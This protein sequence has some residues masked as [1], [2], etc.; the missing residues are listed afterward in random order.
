MTE[1]LVREHREGIGIG[2]QFDEVVVCFMNTG[3]EHEATLE[4]VDR[5]DRHF[6]WGV[7]WL[8]AV[9]HHGERKG[10]THRVVTFETASRDGE[11]FEEY[12]RKYGL[13]NPVS[14]GCSNRLKED[15]LKS[16]LREIEWGAFGQYVNAVGIRADEADRMSA[17]HMA[18]NVIYPMI[19]WGMTKRAVGTAMRDWPFDLGIPGDHYGNC[20]WCWKKSL[21]KHLT[22]MK[23]SPEVFDFPA[24]LERL[25]ADKT[26]GLAKA[27]ED[28]ITR[29]FR[30]HRTTED[31]RRLAEETDFEP[32]RDDPFDHGAELP[33]LDWLDVGGGC[34]ESCE[35]FAD[36]SN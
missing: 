31:L 20:T 11:P 2:G 13:P 34:G 29:M 32:Y 10:S 24:K 6:G 21:R 4:F 30:G 15:V 12:V 28:G 33:Q 5:C 16:Y 35:V 1:R 17:A 19:T 18:K 36:E 8:E 23:E 27:D 25:Y 9:I 22:L 3:C 7:V 26:P 14:K